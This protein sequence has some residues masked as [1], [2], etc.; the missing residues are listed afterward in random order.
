MKAQD[1]PHFY[2][3]TLEEV[4][5]HLSMLLTTA[6]ANRHMAFHTPV[7]I[8]IAEDGRP[9]GRTVV[10]RSFDAASRKLRCHIDRRSAKAD[11]LLRNNQVGWTFYDPALKWQVRLQGTA[12]LHHGDAIAHEAWLASQRMSR[13]C[14]GTDP[15][16]GS[17]ITTGEGF[18]LPADPDAIA[19]GE[20]N[21][22]A[23][24]CTY[25]EME[26]LWLGFKGHRRM[27]YRWQDGGGLQAEWLAP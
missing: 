8:N 9:R 13:V 14:Y 18:T 6:V 19:G 24:V 20:Q 22:A 2:D 4:L 1:E 15:A 3:A 10:L 17:V 21:F 27:R 16:P 7:L 23:L 26:G 25:D 12:S 11:A 5:Q